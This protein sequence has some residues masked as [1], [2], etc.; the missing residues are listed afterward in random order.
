M[1]DFSHVENLV[2]GF[3]WSQPSWSLFILLGWLGV[4]ILY[5]FSA[6]RGR[7]LGLLI[8]IYVSRLLALEV[9]WLHKMV[10]ERL[11]VAD[12]DLQNLV[13]FGVLFV[14]IF[15]ALSKHAFKLSAE[16]R[17]VGLIFII[18]FS[19]LQVGLL[20]SIVLGYLPGP[21]RDGFAPLVQQVFL[22]AGAKVFWLVSPVIFLVVFGRFVANRQEV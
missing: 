18:I 12:G 5:A 11:S 1:L 16:G 14:I 19:V 20:T 3:N 21:V 15:L 8:A 2:R 7:V 10:A 9:P 13:V 22:Y 17:G 6:G 4:S